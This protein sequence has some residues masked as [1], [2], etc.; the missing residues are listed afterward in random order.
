MT[1]D[2]NKDLYLR[3]QDALRHPEMLDKVLA[4]DFVAYDLP[5]AHRGRSDFIRFR[6]RVSKAGDESFT[7][8]YLIAEG[9]LVAAHLTVTIRQ[10]TGE[11]VTFHVTEMAEIRDG[12]VAWR[13]TGLDHAGHALG[14]LDRVYGDT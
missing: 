3:Y 6:E 14:V 2:E 9:D 13:R 4:P 8:D 12:R 7:V 1:A 5:Q 10:V 11:R